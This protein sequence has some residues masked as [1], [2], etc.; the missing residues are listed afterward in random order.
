M[1]KKGMT[2]SQIHCLKSVHSIPLSCLSKDKY[3]CVSLL[4]DQYKN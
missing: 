2:S 3:Q 1:G 4:F